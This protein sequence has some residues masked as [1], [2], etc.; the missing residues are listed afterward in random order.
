MIVKCRTVMKYY[1]N[2]FWCLTHFRLEILWAAP[3]YFPMKRQWSLTLRYFIN[4]ALLLFSVSIIMV[5]VHIW[6][7]SF[8]RYD[9]LSL[10]DN[11]MISSFLKFIISVACF[12]NLYKSFS[13]ISIIIKL[14]CFCCIKCKMR[15]KWKTTW[16][17]Q[18]YFSCWRLFM[19]VMALVYLFKKRLMSA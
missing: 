9:S 7:T 6:Q 13:C 17:I 2:F 12:L 5:P 8:L 11:G 4:I 19:V 3:L 14:V 15:K 10:T 18:I 16:S 1:R